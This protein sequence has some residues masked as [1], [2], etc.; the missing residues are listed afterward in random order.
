MYD[1]CVIG[2]C[3][4]V[5]LPLALA[6]ANKGKKVC[7]QDLNEN[8]VET[9]SRGIMPF[10]EEGAEALLQKVLE[11]GS[12]AVTT[13]QEPISESAVVIFVIGTPVDEHLNPKF[14][15]MQDAIEKYLDYFRDGQL[16]ILRSTL[17]P[18]ISEKIYRQIL[19]KGK[20]IHV[21]FCPERILEGHALSELESLPQIV[22]SFSQEGLERSKELFSLLTRDLVEMEPMEAELAKLFTNVW[23]YIKFAT[24][25]QFYML[26]NEYNL[27]F[28]KIHYG[29]TH[30]YDR[31]KDLPKPG[32]SAGPC[33]FKDA[34]QLGAFNDG[35][36]YLGH[37]AMLINEGMPNY[38]VKKLKEKHKLSMMNVGILGMAFKGESDDTRESLSYKL[39]KIL[40]IEARE[41]LCADPYVKDSR[42]LPLK[43]VLSRSDILIIAAPHNEYKA[44]R[45]EALIKNKIVADIWNIMGN[46]GII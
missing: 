46:G 6:L 22:S 44:L 5:G 21:A 15:L 18:G 20:N 3:G 25:N 34:M 42:I 45:N 29:M 30:N 36:F 35:N 23:R 11:E 2:G 19:E 24:A 1:V 28:Y 33:L 17:Y 14:S 26:A 7:A 37:T 43:E 27:D 12:L 41:V 38:V 8:A 4:H 16:L 40:E 13:R 10:M 9:V 39:K 32:F 31:A